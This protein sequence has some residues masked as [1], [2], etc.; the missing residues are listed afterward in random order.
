MIFCSRLVLWRESPDPTSSTEVC[1]NRPPLLKNSYRRHF[2]S[3]RDDFAFLKS[4]KDALPFDWG[5]VRF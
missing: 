3:W 1:K 4:Q 5:D 2:S